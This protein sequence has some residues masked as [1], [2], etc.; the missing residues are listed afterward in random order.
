MD[1]NVEEAEIS[2]T[3]LL[4]IESNVRDYRDM[5]TFLSEDIAVSGRCECCRRYL[6][7]NV[8]CR[9]KKVR[10]CSKKCLKD[11][12]KYHY[13]KCPRAGEEENTELLKQT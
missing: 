8:V 11:D 9:C 12:V 5:F 13:R 1:D 7:L 10:Y 2:K 3:D 6:D 4:L